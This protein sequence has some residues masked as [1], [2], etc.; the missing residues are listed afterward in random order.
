MLR[1]PRAYKTYTGL[2][3][4]SKPYTSLARASPPRIIG[5]LLI[6]HIEPPLEKTHACQLP[7]MQDD[8]QAHLK[9]QSLH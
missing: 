5:L 4:L 8:A 7:A 9:G 3:L 1:A 2:V 6:S